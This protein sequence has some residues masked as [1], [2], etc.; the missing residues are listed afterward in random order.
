[1]ASQLQQILEHPWVKEYK[2]D[3]D[4]FR[5]LDVIEEK[6]GVDRLYVVTGVIIVLFLGL[7]GAFGGSPVAN[8]VGFIYPTYKSYKALKS[9]KKDDDTQWLTY[10]VV[11]SFFIVVESFTDILMSWIPMYYIAKICFLLFCMSSTFQGSSIIFHKFIEP[12]L[13][14]S[15][16][17][18]DEVEEDMRDAVEDLQEQLTEKG[19]E[20][21]VNQVLNN[22]KSDSAAS[23]PRAG[24]EDVDYLT[25]TQQDPPTLSDSEDG[26]HPKSN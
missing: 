22:N 11:Y 19:T 15:S 14:Y 24:D 8:L 6:L 20:F 13:D 25:S 7:L 1:M 12:F 9:E 23:T 4:Q 26:Y 21:V 10:W 2:H 3:L 17:S 16:K 18:L 5:Q